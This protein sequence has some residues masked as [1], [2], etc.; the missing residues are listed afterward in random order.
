MLNVGLRIEISCLLNFRL[1]KDAWSC[2]LVLQLLLLVL[3]RAVRIEVLVND[4][5][6]TY[7]M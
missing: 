3:I 6:R 5:T 4:T 1:V 2:C 7:I